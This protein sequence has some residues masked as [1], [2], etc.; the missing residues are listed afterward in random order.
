[1][2]YRALTSFSGLLSMSLGDVREISDKDIVKDLLKAGYIEELKEMKI[3]KDVD[4]KV[5]K[6]KKGVKKKE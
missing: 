1:M 6:V 3:T 5:T 2:K 4:Q